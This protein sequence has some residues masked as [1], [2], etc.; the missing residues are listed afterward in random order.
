VPLT[1]VR[2][3]LYHNCLISLS[4]DETINCLLDKADGAWYFVPIKHWLLILQGILLK[5]AGVDIFWKELLSLAAL[6]L[7]INITTIFFLRRRLE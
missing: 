5:G 4:L 3:L 1:G 7:L 6:G 2:I